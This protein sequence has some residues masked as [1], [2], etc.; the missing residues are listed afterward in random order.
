MAR[1]VALEKVA[2]LLQGR[3]VDLMGRE[4]RGRA[5]ELIFPLVS[6]LWMLETEGWKIIIKFS[7]FSCLRK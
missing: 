1:A 3:S 6:H 7:S 5:S 4:D 2:N